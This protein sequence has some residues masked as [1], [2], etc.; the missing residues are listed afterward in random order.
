[1]HPVTREKP[2]PHHGCLSR[3]YKES[4]GAQTP[5]TRRSRSD[6]SIVLEHEE[7]HGM[8]SLSPR[9]I[10]KRNVAPGQQQTSNAAEVTS[11]VRYRALREMAQVVAEASRR[12]GVLVR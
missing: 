11:I 12:D 8:S 5:M 6:A 1:D 2:Q 4:P 10:G 9:L 7:E 3:A